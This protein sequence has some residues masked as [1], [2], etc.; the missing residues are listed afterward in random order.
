VEQRPDA[1]LQPLARRELVAAGGELAAL[2]EIAAVAKQR[3]GLCRLRVG[4]R[5]LPHDAGDCDAGAINAYH[6]G[7]R[8]QGARPAVGSAAS[9]AAVVVAPVSWS[10]AAPP[11]SAAAAPAWRASRS[12]QPPRE[13]PREALAS[14]PSARAPAGEQP[15]ETSAARSAPAP[16]PCHRSAW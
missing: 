15:R 1:A 4:G 6:R 14:D 5:A 3:L 16:V 9:S 11:A 7:P 2:D 12:A 10:L 13:Q 8:A